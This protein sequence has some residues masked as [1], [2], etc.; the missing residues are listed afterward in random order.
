M[1]L[2]AMA[3]YPGCSGAFKPYAPYFPSEVEFRMGG[4]GLSGLALSDPRG[5]FPGAYA[6]V[7]YVANPITRKVQAIKIHRNGPWYRYELLG[8]FVLCS[9][10][11]F[12][13]V[14]IHFGPDGC[15]YIIDWYNKII[16]HNEVPRTHPERDK[17]RGRIWR[18]RH[19]D[20]P[21]TNPPNIAKSGNS[22]LLG[23][24]Q[25]ESTWQI[26]AAWW[27]I[28]DR[29]LQSLSPDLKRIAEDSRRSA[30]HRIHAFWS[31]EDLKMLTLE[32]VRFFLSDTNRNLRREA[33]R[34][35]GSIALP[36]TQVL[37]I[38]EQF[39]GDPDPEVRAA[40]IRRAVQHS[41]TNNEALTLLARMIQPSLPGPI[42]KSPHSG[43]PM[44]LREAYDRDFER[45]LIRAALE[46]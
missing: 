40:V 16:S 42:A 32:T 33:L 10:E 1:A 44:K 15:L 31:L 21:R 27:Q 26:R 45:Y 13:P 38:L 18:V 11:W 24:L 19:K 29:G 46:K 28:V 41:R 39:Q 17:T 34:A 37:P 14:A 22:E 20:Q 23:Y 9:D 35:I 2:Q 25:T 3:S 43:A 36:V 12:R 4:T 30:T 5:G 7:M 8:D 6:D